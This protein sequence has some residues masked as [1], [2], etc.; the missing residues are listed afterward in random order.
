MK[1]TYRW[2]LILYVMP[3]L[4][5]GAILRAE[6]SFN[7][8]DGEPIYTQDQGSTARL[9]GGAKLSDQ[10]SSNPSRLKTIRA[11]TPL[12]GIK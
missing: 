3:C 12:G 7:L 8:L 6:T 1:N 9:H 11:N 10:G 4:L 2:I 5:S